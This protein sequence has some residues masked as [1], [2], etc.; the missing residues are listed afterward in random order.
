M[1]ENDNNRSETLNNPASSQSN[2]NVKIAGGND[3]LSRFEPS[4]VT[5]GSVFRTDFLN[6]SIYTATGEIAQP[7]RKHSFAS[8]KPYVVLISLLLALF[9]LFGFPF[10]AIFFVGIAIIF[11][12]LMGF[13]S[14]FRYQ[15]IANTP[16][17][18]MESAPEGFGIF[19]AR[20]TPEDGT[21]LI[22]PLSKTPCV[23]YS[24]A[25]TKV[26]GTTKNGPIIR[27]ASYVAKGKNSF[28]YD[29]TGYAAINLNSLSVMEGR[30][31]AAENLALELD[32]AH[33]KLF[34]P[35]PNE[36]LPIKDTIDKAAQAGT[37]P[38]LSSALAGVQTK[39][40]A[41]GLDTPKFYASYSDWVLSEYCI[42]TADDYTVVGYFHHLE[43]AIN[44]KPVSEIRRDPI[45]KMLSITPGKVSNL[46]GSVLTVA[47]IEFVIA[48][49]ILI[50]AYLTL[51]YHNLYL[52]I[53]EFTKPPGTCRTIFGTIIS[54][55]H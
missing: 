23:F 53:D 34:N 14:L 10:F 5:L 4:H 52:C 24:V 1:N 36:L 46:A 55:G 30:Y 26:V 17:S 54:V 43:K 51:T 32:Y 41:K 7:E 38:D 12:L 49:A 16:V 2:G 3:N 19:Q 8:L 27:V 42:S 48:A 25:L 45:T 44:G 11:L 33:V 29:G 28:L 9:C 13:D 47:I 40:I 15:I 50:F 6:S 39:V 31:P 18:K 21:P 20:F 22:A 37:D 35:I